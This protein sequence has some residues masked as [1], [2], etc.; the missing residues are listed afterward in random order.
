[1][2][3]IGRRG[4]GKIITGAISFGVELIDEDE[5]ARNMNSFR[6]NEEV[7]MIFYKHFESHQGR[8]HNH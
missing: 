1:M 3:K 5:N 6:S 4:D 2:E 8:N 7:I